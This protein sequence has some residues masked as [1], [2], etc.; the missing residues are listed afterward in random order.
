M[1]FYKFLAINFLIIGL[2]ALWR[3]EFV[4]AFNSIIIGFL[5]DLKID[6]NSLNNED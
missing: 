5:F 1:F 2:I 6:I 4:F 3:G